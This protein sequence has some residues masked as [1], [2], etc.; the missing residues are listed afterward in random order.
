MSF[1]DLRSNVEPE[2][3]T[4]PPESPEKAN[5]IWKY[6]QVPNFTLPRSI[7]GK[8]TR[9]YRA[10]SSSS[11]VG[12]GIGAIFGELNCRCQIF[13]IET[14]DHR[15]WPS[16][17][18]LVLCRVATSVGFEFQS[19]A[20]RFSISRFP[21][22]RLWE[23]WERVELRGDLARAT[24]TWFWSKSNDTWSEIFNLLVFTGLL[25]C[26]KWQLSSINIRCFST[27]TETVISC[28]NYTK[29]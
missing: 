15:W 23:M 21:W 14:R 9:G 17:T 7:P 5:L 12:H 2:I 16:S 24:K 10:S 6:I 3:K 22:G 8:Q 13:D 4:V 20:R 1:C 11:P 19:G 28:Q 26:R 18:G 25:Q 29:L 27:F